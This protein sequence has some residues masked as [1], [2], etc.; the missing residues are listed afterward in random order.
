MEGRPQSVEQK[1]LGASAVADDKRAF[2][3]A[4]N[5]TETQLQGA[6]AS[7]V[8][9]DKSNLP[10]AKN[11][12]DKRGLPDV[13]K[14]NAGSQLQGAG[15]VMQDKNSWGLVAGEQPPLHDDI[16]HDGE[17]APDADWQQPPCKKSVR[18]KEPHG[19]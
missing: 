11:D 8:A 14:N 4:K 18:K 3:N 9:D 15:A 12:G 7:A 17:D 2:P 6:G 16:A 10:N 1:Q 13:A 19:L 5:G